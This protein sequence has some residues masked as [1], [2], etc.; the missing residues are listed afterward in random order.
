MGA[1]RTVDFAITTKVDNAAKLSQQES[2]QSFGL[3]KTCIANLIRATRGFNTSQ[4]DLN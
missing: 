3:E 4:S 1:K 2:L